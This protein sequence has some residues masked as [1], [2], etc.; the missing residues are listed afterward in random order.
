AI[1][2]GTTERQPASENLQTSESRQHLS[3]SSSAI[4]AELA[5]S[6][7][8]DSTDN[9][10]ASSVEV[11]QQLA[12]ASGTGQ[13]D[14]PFVGH[15]LAGQELNDVEQTLLAKS[16]DSYTLQLLGSHSEA[17]VKQF[18]ASNR[19]AAELSYFES[20]HE[21]RPWFVVVHGSYSDRSAA[22]EAIDR[23]PPVLRELQ[24]W[25]RNL[26]DIQADIRSHR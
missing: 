20:R 16:P 26:S 3:S 7:S 18:I 24:P 15:E 8:A 25:A 2:S 12:R 10:E 13:P 17:S 23:L 4:A 9:A 5:G 1:A 6:E 14:E 11:A 19:A 21:D 22:R